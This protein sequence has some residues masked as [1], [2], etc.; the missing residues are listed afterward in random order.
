MTAVARA[1]KPEPATTGGSDGLDAALV[2]L[3]F[4]CLHQCKGAGA[5]KGTL[6]HVVIGPSGV[7]VVHELHGEMRD[8]DLRAVREHAAAVQKTLACRPPHAVLSVAVA[9]LPG[10]ADERD[11]VVIVGANRVVDVVRH[12]A[13]VLRPEGVERLAAK[14]RAA[15]DP[16]RA[17]PRGA[18]AP[19]VEKQKPK[20]TRRWPRRVL[21]VVVLV[22]AAA[23]LV[24]VA[25]DALSGDDAAPV[26]RDAEMAVSFECRHPGAGWSQVISWDGME[27]VRSVAWA[28]APEGPWVAL[29]AFGTSAVRDGV[30][31]GDRSHVRI[32]RAT[33]GGEVVDA[34][35][36]A[37]AP[38][39]AC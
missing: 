14:G 11:G 28:A 13:V 1:T 26:A 38:D 16:R 22:A 23:A 17:A 36:A 6:D 8:V 31:P 3:G 9:A 33:D 18:A 24:P 29:S 20:R 10:G 21:L 25:R 30:G 15:L 2:P 32:E 12:A 5:R 7:W 37:T 19:A 27:N 39:H 4:H 35:A 34:V